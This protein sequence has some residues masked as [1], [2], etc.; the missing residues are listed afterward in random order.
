[1]RRFQK[2]AARDGYACAN[3]GISPH[4]LLS[5]HNPADQVVR[6][7]VLQ[8][9]EVVRGEDNVATAIRLLAQAGRA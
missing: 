8:Q 2:H 9:V 7:P 6:L 1:M 3:R 4:L 5:C